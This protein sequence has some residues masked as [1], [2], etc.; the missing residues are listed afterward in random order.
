[1]LPILPGVPVGLSRITKRGQAKRA[2]YVLCYKRE[3]DRIKIG[4]ATHTNKLNLGD[5][6]TRRLPVPPR[7]EQRRIVE[8]LG[9]LMSLCDRLEVALASGDRL[10]RRLLDSLLAEALAPSEPVPA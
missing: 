3:F 10:R 1:V 9:E 7:A 2:D 6:R 5:L 8:K 4:G